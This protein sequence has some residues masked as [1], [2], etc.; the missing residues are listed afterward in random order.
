MQNSSN[1]NVNN[2]HNKNSNSITL[3]DILRVLKKNW[4]LICIITVVVFAIGAIYT[5][6]IAKPTYKST[7]SIVV[8]IP[9]KAGA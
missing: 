2:Q 9:E 7:S 1:E 5:F 3:S 8:A 6:A 4:I